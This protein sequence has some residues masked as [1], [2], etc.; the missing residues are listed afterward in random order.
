MTV[1]DFVRSLA[2]DG[3]PTD[4]ALDALWGNLRRRLRRALQRRGL[5]DRPPIYLGISGGE[6]WWSDDRSDDGGVPTGGGDALDEMVTDFYVET[7]IER[8]P[9]LLRYVEQ[10]DD[11]E[12]VVALRIRQF[13]HQRQRRNDPLG[14]ALFRWLRDALE[15]ATADGRLAIESS[16]AAARRPKISNDTVFLAG[17][18]ASE[19]AGEAALAAAVSRWSNDL[20]VDW[21]CARGLRMRPLVDRLAGHLAGL[22]E[23]GV[24]RFDLK[25]LLDVFKRDVRQRL[26]DLLGDPAAAEEA[27]DDALRVEQRDRIRAISGCVEAAIRQGGGQQ[28]TRDQLLAL[29]RFLERFALAADEEIARTTSPLSAAV[30]AQEELPSHRRLSRLLGIRHDRFP[31]LLARLKEEVRHCLDSPA[32][33]DPRAYTR[34]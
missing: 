12:R 18:A 28:R 29:W 6:A 26:A 14:H 21:A 11:L 19:T 30:L 13:L 24:A 3:E 34:S 22:G 10:G 17:S 7:F 5:W 25:S 20:L 15:L 31:A 27:P 4:H 2:P 32:G 23:A 1:A 9:V 33:R 16:G 8:L